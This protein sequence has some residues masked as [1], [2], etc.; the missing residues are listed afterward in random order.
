MRIFKLKLILITGLFSFSALSACSDDPD[1]TYPGEID[2]TEYRDVVIVGGG[3]SGLTCG[4]YLGKKD[5]LILEKENTVGGRAISGVRNNFS[6]A[7]GAEYLGEP[8]THL[9][10]MIK[11]LGLTPKEIPS[12]MDAYF[13]G[14][15][16]YWGYDGIERYL[17]TG[18]SVNEYKRFVGLLQK[19]YNEYDDIPDLD[20]N[21]HAKELDYITAKNWL[22]KNNISNIYINKYN[23][24]SRG[25]FGASL[26]NISALSFIPEAAFDFEDEDINDITGDFD[27]KNEY[28]DALKEKSESYTFTKGLTELTNRL[29]EVMS[30]NIRVNSTV[31]E[32]K[33][34]GDYY[35]ITYINK[36][37]EEAAVLANDVV[38]AIPA[39]LALKIAGSLIADERKELMSKIEFSSYAT[40]ALFSETP[41]FD[42][43]F[44][45][46]VPDNYF[47]TDI[48]DATWVER[49]YTKTTPETHIIS[50]YVA[51]Q[52][53][54]DHSLDNMSD[55]ELIQRIYNDLN[56]VFPGASDKVI[57]YDIQ[58]F[59]YAYP[60]M[61]LGAYERLIE[62][63]K[64]NNG[65][66]LFA[67]DYM[68]Y[69]TF[70]SAA[71]SGYQ[72]AIKIK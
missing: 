13:D 37:G 6:Y 10:K 47:F 5:F 19:E 15:S 50:I 70:E 41:I 28:A 42:K 34:D 60:V 23:V 54:T 11:E 59:S 38:L 7:K 1:Y 12:P 69:P 14:K 49:Y 2:G 30:A 18:S 9:A 36:N 4:Y 8:E 27:I 20:Y 26:E 56:K 68:I 48:Y 66:L 17:I 35:R 21:A 46:A 39:P 58:H 51:P 61:T 32:V 64:L 25:L 3:I 24:A 62:L 16:F 44:D 57:D 65:T 72:A 67:G 22:Q 55:S 29:G 43:A 71:E 31:T 40:V 33:K 63:D 53:Y 45:L 52:T